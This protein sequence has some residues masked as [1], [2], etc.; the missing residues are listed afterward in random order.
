MPVG[1]I[2]RNPGAI[3]L[4]II[5]L[6]ITLFT[7]PADRAGGEAGVIPETVRVG[8]MQNA[9][10]VSFSFEGAY[11]LVDIETGRVIAE[12]GGKHRWLIEDAGGLLA[13][14]RDGSQIGIFSGPV[15]AE[16]TGSNINVLAEKGTLLHNGDISGMAV[17][18]G[19]NG[20]VQYIDA[21]RRDY[22]L[23]D[24]NGQVQPLPRGQLNLICLEKNGQVMRYRGNLE[25]RATGGGLTVINE[26]PVE[27]YLYGVVPAEMPASF[28]PEALKAQAVAARSYLISQ[29]GSYARYGFDVL[30]TQSNHVY[31][32]FNKENPVT[33]RVVDETRGLVLAYHQQPVAAFYHS[34]SGGFT[35]NSEDIWNSYLA[36]IRAKPDPADAN[37]KHYNWTVHYSVEQLTTLVNNKLKSYAQPG[38]LKEFSAI[39]DLIEVERT[40]TGQRVKKLL[41]EGVDA[42]GNP[43]RVSISNADR[44]RSVL[45]LKSALFIINKEIGPD[46]KMTG[47]VFTGS[48]WGHG[49]GL[50][51]WGARG[52][53]EKGYSFQDILQYY[54]TDVDLVANY[55]MMIFAGK[56]Q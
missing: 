17:A 20:D 46:G 6:L 8:L 53:A 19:L 7:W 36:Y 34:S 56:D 55:G 13:V 32:G 24:G 28:P 15:R 48:G 11:K 45:G 25:V 3:G 47:V 5:S 44:V 22:Y 40:S 35:E 30:D 16:E 38:E 39:T 4:L 31:G 52:L 54:Y 49:L 26:L 29:L 9:P 50:S 12:D 51:Q 1:K 33:T 10:R 2:K 27:H 41:I 23:M 43:A 18:S 14:L 37:D 21:A 42:D